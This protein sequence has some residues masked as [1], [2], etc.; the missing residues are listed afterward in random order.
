M[1]ESCRILIAQ[2]KIKEAEKVINIMIEDNATNEIDDN[3]LH[4]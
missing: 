4:N 1:E 3:D 2:N